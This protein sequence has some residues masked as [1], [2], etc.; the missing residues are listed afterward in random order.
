MTGSEWLDRARRDLDNAR[1]LVEAGGND[2]A[3][4]RAYYAAF[5][6]AK[7]ALNCLGHDPSTHGG[8]HSAFGRYVLK[9]GGGSPTAGR[10]LNRLFDRR[11]R[12]DYTTA[13]LTEADAR[14]AIDRARVVVDAVEAW[15]AGRQG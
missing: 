6:A 5:Y 3:V 14:D 12:A 10:A 13:S 8:V 1:L 9:E 2:A 4:S 15:L 11:T 7:A